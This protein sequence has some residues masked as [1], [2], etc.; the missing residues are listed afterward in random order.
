MSWGNQPL[1]ITPRMFLGC[2]IVLKTKTKK[3]NKKENN[4]C[5]YVS[6]AK[7]GSGITFKLRLIALGGSGIT[8]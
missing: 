3:Q 8:F 1:G 4:I 2:L 5:V 7:H 6:W